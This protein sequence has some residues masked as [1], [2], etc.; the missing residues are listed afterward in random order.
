MSSIT[1]SPQHIRAL[2]LLL[3]V[4]FTCLTMSK[5][6]TDNFISLPRKKRT[7]KQECLFFTTILRSCRTPPLVRF[8]ILLVFF[9]PKQENSFH[10]SNNHRKRER[11]PTKSIIPVLR[12]CWWSTAVPCV[13]SL[14]PHLNRNRSTTVPS[15]TLINTQKKNDRELFAFKFTQHKY[16]RR[17]GWHIKFSRSQ[18]VHCFTIYKGNLE[19]SRKIFLHHIPWE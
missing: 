13:H 4:Y 2:F 17:M 12:L 5:T 18:F 14:V 16:K 9:P 19:S 10:I 6:N 7:N 11:M 15:L 3:S 8:A 1:R